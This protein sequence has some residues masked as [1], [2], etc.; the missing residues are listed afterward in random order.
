MERFSHDAMGGE[1]Y[2]F[3]MNENIWFDKDTIF[4]ITTEFGWSMTWDVSKFN[5]AI[6]VAMLNNNPNSSDTTILA[7]SFAGI[8]PP[9]ALGFHRHLS[10]CKLAFDI[11]FFAESKPVNLSIMFTLYIGVQKEFLVH[12]KVITGVPPEGGKYRIEIIVDERCC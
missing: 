2:K 6:E 12:Q 9:I 11:E 5:R 8:I 10:L 4:N 3:V 1:I 7:K